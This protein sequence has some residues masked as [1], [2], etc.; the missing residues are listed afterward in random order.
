MHAN[1]WYL[2]VGLSLAVAFSARAEITKG[3]LIATGGGMP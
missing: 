1:S 3:V 2:A